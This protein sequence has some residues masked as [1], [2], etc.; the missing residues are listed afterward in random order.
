MGTLSESYIYITG[1][2]SGLRMKVKWYNT[3]VYVYVTVVRVPLM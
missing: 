3:L 1:M 2:C